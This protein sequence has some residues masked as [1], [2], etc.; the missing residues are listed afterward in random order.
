MILL[1]LFFY[2]PLSMRRIELIFASLFI[3]FTQNAWSQ[4]CSG[5]PS[6]NVN[7]VGQPAGVWLSPDHSR[8]GS[9]CSSNNCTSF[10]VVLDTGAAMINLEI[11][12]GAIPTGSL[13]YKINCGP[14]IAVGA[15]ICV[16][17]QYTFTITFCKPGNNPNVYK[18]TS[19]AKP[20]LPPNPLTVRLGC[21]NT[22]TTLGFVPGT[23]T[24]NSIAP[25]NSG[26][27]NYLLSS[28]NSTA[29]NYTPHAGLPG[30]IDYRVC[31]TPQNSICPGASGT[32]CDTFRIINVGPIT[33]TVTPTNPGF[34]AGGNVS[35]TA[36]AGG[37]APPYT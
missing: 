25:G 4:T 37:G 32:F 1:R 35:I 33:G 29:P 22:L 6:F 36:A 11:L 12:S 7:L 9:C 10:N 26:D 19:I 17:G 34:C 15:P 27:Y 18:I 2:H 20:T 30:I 16:N 5:A 24:W 23:V 31:G 21:V 14:P 3:L 28:T 13:F 8:G